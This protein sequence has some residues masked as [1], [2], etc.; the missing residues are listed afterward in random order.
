MEE[1]KFEMERQ[2]K[3]YTDDIDASTERMLQLAEQTIR[4]GED[5]LTELERQGDQ[6][7]RIDAR[8]AATLTTANAADA[9]AKDMG[10]GFFA[11]A[12]G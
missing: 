4:V 6:L 12:L 7:R 2:I 10:R 1:R 5:T 8:A 11:S 3:Q 9:I